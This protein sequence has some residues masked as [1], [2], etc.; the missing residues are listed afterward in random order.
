MFGNNEHTLWVEKW[1][2]VDLEG[3]VG[4]QAIVKKIIYDLL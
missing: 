4:N 2:P 1:R 3:Y